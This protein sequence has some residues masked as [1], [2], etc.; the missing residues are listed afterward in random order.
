MI[1]I[2][3]DAMRVQEKSA[4]RGESY[5]LLA[6]MSWAI[7]RAN[8]SADPVEFEYIFACIDNNPDR[9]IWPEGDHD[10]TGQDHRT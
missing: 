1:E 2:D 8:S 3:D 6:L 7:F 4:R 5:D 10:R 9:V